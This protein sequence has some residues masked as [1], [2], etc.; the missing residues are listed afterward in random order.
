MVNKWSTSEIAIKIVVSEDFCLN[1]VSEE[2]SIISSL[3]GV[4][5]QKQS[6]AKGDGSDPL[7]Q[8]FIVVVVGGC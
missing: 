6:F 8:C 1:Q 3:S 7:F 4:L 2:G 5:V